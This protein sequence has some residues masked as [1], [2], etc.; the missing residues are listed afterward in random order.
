MHKAQ[1]NAVDNMLPKMRKVGREIQE[2][3]R[4]CD[5]IT[6]ER[7]EFY[8]A[9]PD[10]FK[11]AETGAEIQWQMTVLAEAMR[12]LDIAIDSLGWIETRT[13]PNAIDLER[14]RRMRNAVAPNVFFINP[15][16]SSRQGNRL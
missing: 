12:G 6:D 4:I 8:Q 7:R 5:I 16:L 3:R 14:V 9:L 2:W 11:T 1:Q 10:S 13:E 15:R